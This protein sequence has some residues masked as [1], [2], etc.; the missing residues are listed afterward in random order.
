ML[1]QALKNHAK[2]GNVINESMQVYQHQSNWSGTT[3]CNVQTLNLERI[4]YY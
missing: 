2:K 1:L 4:P 3:H